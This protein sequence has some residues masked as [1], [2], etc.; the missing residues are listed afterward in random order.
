MF[1]LVLMSPPLG[2]EGLDET[3]ETLVKKEKEYIEQGEKLLEQEKIELEEQIEQD[4]DDDLERERREAQGFDDDDG[5]YDQDDEGVQDDQDASTSKAPL[6]GGG[7]GRGGGKTG[8]RERKVNTDRRRKVRGEFEASDDE[9]EKEESPLDPYSK[10]SR[11]GGKQVNQGKSAG[12]GR[13]GKNKMELNDED[14]P[15]FF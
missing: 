2:P 10:P 12:R 11:G 15:S 6:R 1:G 4:V 5:Y 9:E 14:F 8:D 13:G 7:R 3:I